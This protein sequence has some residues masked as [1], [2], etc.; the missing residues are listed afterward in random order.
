VLVGILALLATSLLRR[1]F[2]TY[3]SF[4]RYAQ[5]QF[6]PAPALGAAPAS[7]LSGIILPPGNCSSCALDAYVLRRIPEDLDARTADMSYPKSGKV[8]QGEG[9]TRNSTVLRTR[10]RRCY[11]ALPGRVRDRSRRF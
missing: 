8:C 4:V 1:D 6:C 7:L 10:S 3:L 2:R 11:T 9:T 5:A